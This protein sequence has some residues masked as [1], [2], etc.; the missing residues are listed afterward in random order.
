MQGLREKKAH[1]KG[2]LKKEMAITVGSIGSCDTRKPGCSYESLSALPNL[3]FVDL[4]RLPD[5]KS[6]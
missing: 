1:T 2:K 4:L 5:A 6:R 3:I